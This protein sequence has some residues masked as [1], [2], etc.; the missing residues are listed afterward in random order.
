[1][2]Q[3]Y[4]QFVKP[5]D[6]VFNIGANVGARTAVFL[7][8]GAKVVAVEPQKALCDVLRQNFANREVQVVCAACGPTEGEVD[9]LLCTDNMLA[10]C[11]PGWA[12]ALKNR[13]PGE[14]WQETAKVPQVT[15]D[16][17]IDEYGLPDFIKIDVEGYED[18]VFK[19][20]SQPI[21]ALSFEYT[22]P[23]IEPALTSVDLIQGLGLS[24]FNYII[25]ETMQ[26]VSP[27]WM[28]SIE[29]QKTLKRLPI[30][31]FY[32]DIFAI[33]EVSMEDKEKKQDKKGKK[34]ELPKVEVVDGMVVAAP[35][36]GIWC[37]DGDERRWVPDTE[38]QIKMGIGM[39][40]VVMLHPDQ[41]EAIPEGEPMPE[42]R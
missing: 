21:K 1:M 29:I 35:G 33:R 3:L 38:T 40:H 30:S 31:T 41:L 25:Q 42:V 13:W 10:T 18:Q 36:K 15:L 6:L 2:K 19:G 14:K 32:G 20:L 16:G 8:L 12:A 17:L 39:H 22:V 11:A 34:L 26:F 27:G 9:L 37:I 24:H 7:D 4:G 5:R 23:Y 28:T